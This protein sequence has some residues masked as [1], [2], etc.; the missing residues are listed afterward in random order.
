MNEEREEVIHFWKMEELLLEQLNEEFIDLYGSSIGK[1][2]LLKA[3]DPT[4]FR[5]A[6]LNYI[7]FRCKEDDLYETERDGQTVYLKKDEQE[8]EESL[9]F[10]DNYEKHL[11]RYGPKKCFE[12][13]TLKERERDHKELRRVR[14]PKP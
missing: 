14:N 12:N 3:Y 13:T 4:A 10:L 11:L 6:V 5:A 2:D 8:Y 1:G 7:D 9:H